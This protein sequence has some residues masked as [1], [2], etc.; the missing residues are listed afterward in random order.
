MIRVTA[1]SLSFVIVCAYSFQQDID[2]KLSNYNS[3]RC[4]TNTSLVTNRE[5]KVLLPTSTYAKSF[6]DNLCQSKS[7]ASAYAAVSVNWQSRD[8]LT[9]M[10][11]L[12]E[13]FNLIWSR[14]HIM[15][16]LVPE[17]QTLYRALFSS[18]KGSLY[19]LSQ[20]SQPRLELSY[21]KDKTIG[22]LKDT[23]SLS[24]YLLPLNS[25]TSLHLNIEELNIVYY[26]SFEALFEDFKLKKIDLISGFKWHSHNLG[27][28]QLYY[29]QISN[30]YD[31]GNWYVR[32]D[33]YNPSFK[34]DFYC[35]FS[36]YKK[37][38]MDIENSQF[39]QVG[40]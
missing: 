30:Q 13:K 29:T 27:L 6:A 10:N 7:I 22:L 32:Q 23:K 35:A 5:F 8:S 4:S 25:L 11:I 28:E 17:Y 38:F 37:V 33:D 34:H 16:G 31:Y 19:W 21:L 36:A 40:C 2:I 18:T 26:D 14:D 1:T 39:H 15:M 20:S 3:Y 9:A 24:A 12:A